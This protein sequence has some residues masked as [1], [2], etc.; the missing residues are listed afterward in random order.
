MNDLEL[1]AEFSRSRSDQAFAALVERYIRLVHS[2]CWRQLRDAQLAEDATQMVFVLLSQK[3]KSLRH[4]DLSGWLLTTARYTCAN[5]NRA[6]NRRAV[7]EQQVVTMKPTENVAQPDAELLQMLDDGLLKLRAED[8]QALVLRFLQEQP[9][10]AVGEALGLS[11]DAAR[12]RV[13]R[14]LEKLRQFFHDRGVSTDSA[15]LAVVLADHSRVPSITGGLTQR[16][17]NAAKVPHAPAAALLGPKA[18]I[19]A[20]ILM[21][22]VLGAMG[23]GVFRWGWQR[24]V[25]DQVA[26]AP[27]PQPATPASLPVINAP[28]P[29]RST[30]DI[31][32][33]SLCK[34]YQDGDH[35]AV[36]ACLTT[37]PNRPRKLID[38]SLDAGLAERRMFLA[39]Q[40][41]YG[42]DASQL[43]DGMP[44]DK[45]LSAMLVLRRLQ[46]DTAEITGNT[47]VIRTQIPT[48][49]IQVSPA[50]IQEVLLSWSGKPIYFEL[51]DG[52]WR[53]DMDRSIRF[54]LKIRKLGSSVLA[55]PSDLTAIAIVDAQGRD[56]DLLAGR[57]ERGELPHLP[58]AKKARQE[59]FNRLFNK[60]GFSQLSTYSAPVV[61]ERP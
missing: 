37:D 4:A 41:A 10:R 11:E 35:D 53:I 23:W 39:A 24:S 18:V 51:R 20:A 30:P 60:F 36:Y 21:S 25:A 22:V 52:N 15:A 42:P 13:D 12:K 43:I 31:A 49:L 1:V 6:E 17:I 27:A 46:G 55:A 29:D 33:A 61:P 26:T 5:M 54:V 59:D 45:V 2:A 44:F 8:R 38:A 16:I 7:R 19:A 32:L 57:I 40:K 58:D 48:S 28:Q 47:A 50:D 34:V 14:G 56:C 3:A 9:L